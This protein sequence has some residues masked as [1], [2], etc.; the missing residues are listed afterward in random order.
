MG[1]QKTWDAAAVLPSQQNCPA[2]EDAHKGLAAL[3]KKP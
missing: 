2:G 3:T 1:M